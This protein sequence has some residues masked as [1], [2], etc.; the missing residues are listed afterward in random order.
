M[1]IY[2]DDERSC[3]RG[4]HSCRWPEEVIEL[5]KTGVVEAVDLD[6]D[7]GEGQEFLNPRTGMDVLTFLEQWVEDGHVPPRIMI[8]TSNPPAKQRMIA[9]SR[10]IRERW[11]EKMNHSTR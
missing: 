4:W 9:A 5:I 10:A 2:L 8:H 7:L 6:H 3:P 11:H 1:M